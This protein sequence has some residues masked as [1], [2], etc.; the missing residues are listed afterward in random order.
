MKKNILF[1]S[2]IALPMFAVADDNTVLP[3]ITVKADSQETDATGKL[4]KDA[5]LGI[6]GE[7]AVLDTPFSI[8]SYTEQAIKDKQADSIAGILKNDPSIRSTTNSG[9][10][11][12]NFMIR[13]FAVT[14]E[15]ANINGS[16][17]MSPSGRTPTDILSS[18]SVLKGPN[19]LIAGMAPGGSIGG[20]V[21]ATTK[22]ADRDL[23]QV[24]AMYEDGGYYKSGFD[25]ARRFGENKEFGARVSATYGQGEHIVDGLEDKN[26]A[27]VLA[28]D[29]TTDQA[30]INFD[31]YTTRD[32]RD[33]GSPA[34][35]SFSTLKRV[36]AAPDGKLNYFPHLEGMQSA[37]YVGLSGEY[38]LLPNL[39]A[40]AGA[41]FNE[42]E[43]RGHLFGTRMVVRDLPANSMGMNNPALI[44]ANGDAL[45]QYYRVGSKEHNTT[46]NAGLEGQIFTGDISHTLAFRADYLKRKYSQHKGRGAAEVYFPTNIY[47]PSNEGHMP[48]TWPEIVPT[49][50][51]VYV[52]YS[53]SDQISMLDDKLQFILGVR[54]QDMDLKAL[55]TNTKLNADKV[56]PSAAIVVKP[57]GEETSFYASYVEGLVRGATVN[58][59]TDVNNKKTFAP[60]ESKQY[61]VGAKYQGDRWLHTL[62]LYQIKKPSTMTMQLAKDDPRYVDGKTTQ[63]TTDGAKTESK[64]VEYGFSGKVTDDLIVY[65]NLAYIDTEYKKAAMNQ[66]KT[67]EGT[68]EF[69]AGVGVDYQIPLIEGLSVNAFATYVDEQYLT[70]DNTLKL[71]DYTLVDL[72]A[73]YATKLGGVNTTF[74]A[75]V[76]NVADKKYWDGVFT[77]GFTTV[78]AG[79]TYKLGVSFDF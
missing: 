28:F 56:S 61:E 53:L 24:S 20:V 47:N 58:V 6:L 45:A 79:R 5:S 76:D 46:F 51:D 62:A 21:M 69:T 78:G 3:T 32:S 17:G 33:G 23:T 25:V 38:K 72:G 13:G 48:D 63:I 70:A 44:G 12:E 73:K 66:G 67:I 8:Q 39:K 7:K 65:G 22:R 30:K 52:S 34:M 9:H 59:A 26:T 36:L 55:T 18:A 40:F 71:P 4:K 16:Y 2:L 27:A 42:R 77:S 60:F 35:I 31:A 54:Y 10:L 43:Y 75:N 64:G 41:G 50:D 11:N 14:W 29:Y 49:A 1:L 57:F 68:P 15:D 37:N 74:R 19:A